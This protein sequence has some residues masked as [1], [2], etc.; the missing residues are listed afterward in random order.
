MATLEQIGPSYQDT[1][2]W[3]A[4]AGMRI[5][6]DGA[7]LTFTARL[8]REQGWSWRHA[9]AVMAEYSRFLYLAV[10][11]DRPVTPSQDVDEAWHLHLTYTR[12]YWDEL[13]GRILGKPLHHDPTEGGAAQQAHFVDQYAATLARYETVFGAPPRPDIWPVP[14]L[15][16]APPPRQRWPRLVAAGMVSLAA[17]A[18]TTLAANGGAGGDVV[19]LVL[20]AV[21]TLGLVIVLARMANSRAAGGRREQAAGGDGGAGYAGGDSDC[22]SNDSS[23][24]GDG[25]A[26]GCSGGGCGGGCG[27]S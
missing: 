22:N 23:S 20:V 15:R 14:A 11:G 7:V 3:R 18:C 19:P 2:L 27:G 24:G 16:I 13:C 8:A 5:E 26:G 17:A 12:H 9:K 21:A 10:T 4:L 6:P 1:S 25:N